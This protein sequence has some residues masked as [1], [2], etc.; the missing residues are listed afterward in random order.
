MLEP[1]CS[2]LGIGL[3][4]HWRTCKEFLADESF[5]WLK[6]LAI[7]TENKGWLRDEKA[8]H[9]LAVS[10]A[11]SIIQCWEDCLIALL[12]WVGLWEVRYGVFNKREY[13]A[14]FS[15]TLYSCHHFFRMN[16][17]GHVCSGTR[18]YT[19]T[20]QYHTPIQWILVNFWSLGETLLHTEQISKIALMPLVLRSELGRAREK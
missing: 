13:F 18:I 17:K 16:L 9:R 2:L 14:A 10:S 19:Q 6:A 12:F 1:H 15:L 8:R 5:Y 3:L 7:Q 20:K 11:F 4:F